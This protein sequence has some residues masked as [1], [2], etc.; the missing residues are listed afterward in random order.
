M[1]QQNNNVMETVSKQWLNK[2]VPVETNTRTIEEWCFQ[3]DPRQGAI[4]QTNELTSS[5]VSCVS[6][7]G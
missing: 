3:C 6:V 7:E 1:Q 2:H 4:L 5:V